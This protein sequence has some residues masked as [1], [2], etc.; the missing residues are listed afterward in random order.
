MTA[1][2]QNIS[3]PAGD[4]LQLVVPVTNADGS[5]AVLTG[6]SARY[7]MAPYSFSTGTDVF[8]KKSIGSGISV[9]GNVITITLAP[10]DTESA[11]AGKHWHELEVLFADG[12]SST[13]MTGEVT[14]TRTLVRA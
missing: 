8:L 9:A 10:G 1:L 4:S 13:V 6:A 3:L 7:W 11:G 2:A 12:W 14:I 5:D